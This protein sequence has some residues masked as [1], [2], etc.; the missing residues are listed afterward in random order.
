MK[1]RRRA[2]MTAL[3]ALFEIDIAR[4]NPEIV[5]EQRLD[6][7]SLPKSGAA[8][9]RQLVFGV[10]AHQ[11]ELDRLIGQYAPEWPVEQLAVIDRNILRLALFE[12]GIVDTPVKVAIN[13]AVE[14]AK[15]F[16]SDS[17]PRF[18]NG[19][20]GSAVAE[21]EKWVGRLGDSETSAIADGV[22][23]GRET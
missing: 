12:L 8:F 18:I 16:G 9:V 4:H 5:V 3:Q 21:Q 17:S 22:K 1:V 14:L 23:R 15:I 19:V 10:L 20:L 7:A 2:R 13:E 11:R 6:Y